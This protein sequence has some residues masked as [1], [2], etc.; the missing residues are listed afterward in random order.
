M[1]FSCVGT[2]EMATKIN[3]VFSPDQLKSPVGHVSYFHNTE[4]L[5]LKAK[6]IR[7]TSMK[8]FEDQP[9]V[10]LLSHPK[11]QTC[12]FINIQNLLLLP[13][14]SGV[15]FP[16]LLFFLSDICDVHSGGQ[17]RNNHSQ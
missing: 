10:V 9:D 8:C 12:A 1:Y 5:L 14:S 13:D 16:L 4:I 2:L 17:W 6:Q 11:Y 15:F 3:T 7:Y